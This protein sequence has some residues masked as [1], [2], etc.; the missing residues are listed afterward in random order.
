MNNKEEQIIK[1]YDNNN[2]KSK[3]NFKN[4]KKHGEEFMY[5]EDGDILFIANYENDIMQKMVRYKV[6]KKIECD[7]QGNIKE[8]KKAIESY[9]EEQEDKSFIEEINNKHKDWQKEPKI[10][11]EDLTKEINND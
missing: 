10:S 4:G 2:I 7:N 11:I 5:N 8:I 1:H 9:I 6:D 3:C